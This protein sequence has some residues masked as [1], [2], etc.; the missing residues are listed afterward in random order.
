MST[1]ET[2]YSKR[3][4]GEPTEAQ[5]Q[6]TTVLVFSDARSSLGKGVIGNKYRRN[7]LTNLSS[8]DECS[9]FPAWLRNTSRRP[10]KLVFPAPD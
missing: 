5:E 1:R 9:Q 10:H 2:S 8:L 4:R 3:R 6:M 7:I